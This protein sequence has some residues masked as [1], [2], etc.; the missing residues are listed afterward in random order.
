MIMK[1]IAFITI[2]IISFCSASF[3]QTNFKES[4]ST[5]KAAQSV[6]KF[7]DT[8]NEWQKLAIG[9]INLELLKKSSTLALIRIRND[10]NVKQRAKLLKKAIVFQ[11]AAVGR[12][13][14]LIMPEQKEDTMV[15]IVERCEYVPECQDCAENDDCI[16]I[17]A[18]DADKID[19]LLGPKI[20]KKRKN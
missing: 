6:W 13:R 9:I 10:E 7:N 5:Q 16:V 1:Q 12:I 14:F 19:K 20:N 3:A 8:D 15:L 18:R 2:L 4:D 11:K 17:R